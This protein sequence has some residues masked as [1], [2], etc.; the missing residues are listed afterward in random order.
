MLDDRWQALWGL[1]R[2]QLV[3][4]RAAAAH[5]LHKAS[6]LAPTRAEPFVELASLARQA[7]IYGH[8]V[9]LARAAL[10]CNEPT[11]T[12]M[13]DNSA[14]GWR[15]VDELAL[16]AVAVNDADSIGAALDR[17]KLLIK[18][19]AVP[20]TELLRIE[21]NIRVLHKVSQRAVTKEN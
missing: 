3:S 11:N 6:V 21:K 1:A 9:T 15:A 13:Y 5:M 14:Y 17:Y 4:D 10:N 16:S 19:K 12:S 2:T 8:A 7:R 18:L 20:N